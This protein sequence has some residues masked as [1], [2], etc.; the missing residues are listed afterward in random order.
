MTVS[1][2]YELTTVLRG[3]LGI[4]AV[5]R[6]IVEARPFAVA[7]IDMMM[8]VMDGVETVKSIWKIDPDIRVVF[9]TAHTESRPEDIFT[10][11]GRDDL[12]YLNKP[13]SSGE[14][15]HLARVL[16]KE[17]QLDMIYRQAMLEADI[18]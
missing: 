3:A 11:V 9:V 7:F 17:W 10:V 1:P 13:L 14:I 18:Q 8:P 2:H 6:S 15:R 4:A 12:F 16:S 5:K